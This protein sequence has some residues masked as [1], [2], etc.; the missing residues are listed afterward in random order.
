[1]QERG[2]ISEQVGFEKPD[3][4]VLATLEPSAPG[5]AGHR[6]DILEGSLH[7]NGHIRQVAP[8][9]AL[10]LFSC[11]QLRFSQTRVKW[12]ACKDSRDQHP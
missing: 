10:A 4:L 8:K 3:K 7:G 11:P 9:A 1:M 2:D 6:G 12:I 5:L